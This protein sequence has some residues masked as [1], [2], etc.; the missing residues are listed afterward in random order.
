ML[1][2]IYWWHN[3]RGGGGG[4]GGGWRR[5]R[6][7]WVG[8]GVRWLLPC[9]CVF[10]HLFHLQVVS[11][12]H[13]HTCCTVCCNSH[14]KR[15]AR[16]FQVGISSHAARVTPSA[17]SAKKQQK[18]KK[19][20][21]P[22]ELPMELACFSFFLFPSDTTQKN[23]FQNRKKRNV[24]PSFASL[25]RKCQD[26]KRRKNKITNNIAPQTQEY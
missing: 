13:T 18:K 15:P 17:I 22:V 14:L 1:L 23:I 11:H 20:G 16:A 26:L 25:E 19:K 10:T 4:G 8:A 12:T 24:P 21:P 3:T 2:L 5:R 9:T 7:C 6:R